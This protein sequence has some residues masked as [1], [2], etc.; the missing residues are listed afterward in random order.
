M[1]KISSLVTGLLMMVCLGTVPAGAQAQGSE[2]AQLLTKSLGVT[3]EQANGGAGALFELAKKQLNAEDFSKIAK[4]V[5]GMDGMLAAA[6][7]TGGGLASSLGSMMGGSAGGMGTVLEQFKALG[8][9]S[10]M[11]G[12]FM[13]VISKY[14]ESKGGK[15][16][17]SL[18]TSAWK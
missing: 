11:V 5:P 10:E 7:K 14:V 16:L 18:L 9:S 17:A 2:V 4:A 13:P 12:R 6:P 3:P 1:Q 8:L 15:T